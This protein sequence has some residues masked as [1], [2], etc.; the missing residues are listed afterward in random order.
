MSPKLSLNPSLLPP[1]GAE[2]HGSFQSCHVQLCKLFTAERH[3]AE[4]MGEAE[5]AELQLRLFSP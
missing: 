5:G 2:R 4:G 3:E 1:G